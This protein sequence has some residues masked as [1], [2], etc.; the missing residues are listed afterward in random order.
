[1]SDSSA[2][3]VAVV[4]V[5][6]RHTDHHEEVPLVVKLVVFGDPHAQNHDVHT[7]LGSGLFGESEKSSERKERTLAT[8]LLV[9]EIEEEQRAWPSVVLALQARSLM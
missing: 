4:S 3:T 8:F 5:G 6:E 9:T 1:M 7:V 2:T